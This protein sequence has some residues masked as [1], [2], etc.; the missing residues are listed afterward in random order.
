LINWS[1]INRK[2]DPM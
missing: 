2:F 1:R